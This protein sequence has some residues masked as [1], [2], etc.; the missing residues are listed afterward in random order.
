MGIYKVTEPVEIP[1]GQATA[2][3][4]PSLRLISIRDHCRQNRRQKSHKRNNKL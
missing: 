1:P 4:E 2:S 3:L